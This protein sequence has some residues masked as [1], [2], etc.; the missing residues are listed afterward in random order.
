M[1]IQETEK[2]LIIK[3]IAAAII[4]LTITGLLVAFSPKLDKWK[5]Q[6]RKTRPKN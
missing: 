4:C 5:K 1:N 2:Q 6:K 3:V